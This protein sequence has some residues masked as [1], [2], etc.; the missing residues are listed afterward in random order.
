MEKNK[1]PPKRKLEVKDYP[2]FMTK[3]FADFETYRNNTLQKWHDKTKLTG[4]IG[5]VRLI[6]IGFPQNLSEYFV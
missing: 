6:A 3:R 5:K 4:K 1:R 2:E